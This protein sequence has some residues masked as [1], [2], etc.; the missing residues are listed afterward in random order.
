MF[1]PADRESAIARVCAAQPE[2]EREVRSL[3]ASADNVGAFLGKPALGR[4]AEQIARDAALEANDELIGATLGAYRILHRHAAGGMGTAYLAERAD[5]QFDQKV[6][7][8]VVKRGMDSEEVLR[9]FSAERQTLAALDHPNIARLIDAG[10]TPDGSPFL[11]M[12]MVEGLPIDRYC[13][14]HR[15]GVRERLALFRLVCDAVQH[16]H[17]HLVIHRDIKPGNILVTP[18]GVP[19]LLDFGISKLLDPP[20][21]TNPSPP[22]PT[23][24]SPPNTPAQSRSRGARSRPPPTCTRWASF[25]TNC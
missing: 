23:A 16:A 7:I 22:K 2:L 10:A 14:H 8:K 11:V 17:Q 21:R 13:D 1:S 19:K 24:D 15:L 12:E 20:P 3:L 5:G 4:D 9:R 25:S 6:A 18:Q